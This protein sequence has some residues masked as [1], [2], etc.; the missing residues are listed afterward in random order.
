M[1]ATRGRELCSRPLVASPLEWAHA[2][3]LTPALRPVEYRRRNGA[4]AA[5]ADVAGLAPELARQV[6]GRELDLQPRVRV[7]AQGVCDVHAV[8][9]L[10]AR[11]YRDQQP[12]SGAVLP[13]RVD[14]ERRVAGPEAAGVE[15]GRETHVRG[16]TD[17]ADVP[18]V[19]ET[20]DETTA[21]ADLRAAIAPHAAIGV[22]ERHLER[23]ALPPATAPL[24]G[25]H[26]RVA[27]REPVVR[28]DPAAAEN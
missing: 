21:A 23:H 9:S 27:R 12:E 17:A 1:H 24:R 15:E 5:A 2:S 26:E 19:L 16:G 28:R 3:R 20:A 4:L 14:A 22:G 11:R 7:G 18:A 10:R 13:S 8:E 25:A 6:G